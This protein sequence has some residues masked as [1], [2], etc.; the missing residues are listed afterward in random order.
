MKIQ[1]YL[2]VLKRR[3]WLIVLITV[4]TAA[5]ALIFSFLQTP[6][7][8]SSVDVGIQAARIDWGQAQTVKILLDSY[9]TVIHTRPWA[10]RVIEDLDLML[11]PETLIGDV[12]IASDSQN[13]TIQI[14]VDAND[15]EQ[16]NRIAKRWAELFVEW[17][18]SENQKQLKEDRVFAQI[19]QE[20]SYR[21]LRPKW[22]I[23][24]A[25]GAVFGLLLG[26]LAVIALEWFEAGI[27][28]T[29]RALEEQTGLTVVGIIPPVAPSK[30]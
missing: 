9:V 25:A 13:L 18:N 24:T 8:R 15:G 28:R 26:V 5:S 7:Y 3:G 30:R 4:L 6:V 10:Q 19:L 27:I 14:D 29:P 1:D 12:I 21:L 17:R 20:P 16:A 22:K 23:N 11:E 2:R